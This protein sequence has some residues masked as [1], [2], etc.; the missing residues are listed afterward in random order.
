MRTAQFL[1]LSALVVGLATGSI[2]PIWKPRGP[3]GNVPSNRGA[4]SLTRVFLQKSYLF[5]GFEEILT[6]TAGVTINTFNND[7]FEVDLLTATFTKLTPRGGVK[8]PARGFHCAW[9]DPRIGTR[10]FFI[11]GG[12]NYDFTI[13]E[14]TAY[15]D[16]W[17]FNVFTQTWEEIHPTNSGP[18]ERLGHACASFGSKTVVHGGVTLGEFGFAPKGD[19]WTYNVLT[20]SWQQLSGTGDVPSPR[21]FH[22]AG[23]W[24][25]GGNKLVIMH[26][27]TV[28]PDTGD[29]ILLRDAYYYDFTT[30]VWTHQI[31]TGEPLNQFQQQGTMAILDNRAVFQTDDFGAIF[32]DLRPTTCIYNLATRVYDQLPLTGNDVGPGTKRISTTVFGKRM[33]L[34]T[35]WGYAN[36]VQYWD[37]RLWSYRFNNRFSLPPFG[38]EDLDP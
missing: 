5:G 10:A 15:N 36:G 22:S 29:F 11:F 23:N 34:T 3:F 17:R 6:D 31:T 16:L 30:Q 37:K 28:N 4:A 20:N 13:G 27:E 7:V 12:A 9:V 1:L 24:E 19:A 26:G 32:P 14:F 33:Y 25:D 35:G 2:F 21:Y 8:P 38:G 18:D